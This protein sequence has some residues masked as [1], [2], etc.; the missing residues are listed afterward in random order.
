ML[1]YMETRKTEFEKIDRIRG[2]FPQLG[3]YLH[4]NKEDKVGE[5]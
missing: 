1:I 2:E 5:N 3:V 4:G